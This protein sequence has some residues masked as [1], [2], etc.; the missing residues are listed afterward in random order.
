MR[1]KFVLDAK[2][3]NALRWLEVR[4]FTKSIAEIRRVFAAER[5]IW[6]IYGSRAG[7]ELAEEDGEVRERMM[8]RWRVISVAK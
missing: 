5:Q 4:R 6:R 7:L 8:R 2:Y 3:Q 1:A